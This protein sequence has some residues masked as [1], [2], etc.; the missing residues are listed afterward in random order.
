MS[1]VEKNEDAFFE[2]SKFSISALSQKAIA[3]DFVYFHWPP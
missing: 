3:H 2:E 1:S